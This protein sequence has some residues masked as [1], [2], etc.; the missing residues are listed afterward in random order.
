MNTKGILLG[1]M[2]IWIVS[3]PST[4]Q[5]QLSTKNKKAIE[6]YVEADNYRVRGQF[7]QAIS[8]LQQAIEKDKGF[9]EA[10]FRLGVTYKMMR[11]LDRS[12]KSYEAGLYLTI[13]QK[14][15]KGYFFELGDNYLQVGNYEK[16]RDFLSRYLDSEI[17]NKPK[18][19]QA[20]LWKRTADYAIKNKRNG[21][22]F[23]PRPLSD[24]VNC[25]PMQY[26]PVLTADEQELIFTRRLGAGNED[27]EDLVITRK[28]SAGHWTKP[29]SISPNVNSGYNEGT[30][31]ISADGRQLIFTS[32][33]GRKGFGNCDLFQSLRVGT[34]WSMPLNMGPQINSPAWESQPAL[35][36][37]GRVLYFLSDRKGGLGSR[38]IYVSYQIEPNKW[39]KAENL[40]PKINT[41]YDEISPFIHVNGRT[42]FFAANGRLGFGGYDLFR[43]EKENGEWQEPVN[44][45]YPVNN[46]EDQFSLFITADG[47]RG[48]YSHEEGSMNTSGKIYEI[49]VPED[50]QIKFRSNYVKGKVKD[51]KTGQ[52]LNARIELYD[53]AK[54]ELV[55]FVNSDSVT[56]EYLMVL[57]QGSEYGIFVSKMEYVFQSL[58]FNYESEINIEPVEVNVFLDKVTVGAIS[59][60]KNI[61]FEFDRF[62]LQDKSI[63][64]LE[65]MVR[66][67]TDNP[68][69]K[70]E[71]GGH[72]DND[73]SPAYNI[74]LSQNRA[75]SVATYLIQNGIDQKRISQKG[76]G[77]DRPMKPND[78]EE[79]K[80]DNRR[81]EFKILK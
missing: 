46:H 17:L 13:D 76:Y 41:P 63:T 57:T 66:F 9:S 56:G 77:A 26:F 78:S 3:F 20:S 39:T 55:S 72:T 40:G 47:K 51:K 34:T 54:N 44:F 79:N 50:L 80:Q 58:N 53:V 31:T 32:C 4:A 2:I 10:Y 68:N 59:V 36:A 7:N 42:L 60:L 75:Q 11:D 67:L 23:V 37:D 62:D 27:D 24:T 28:D 70:V 22:G 43:S 8:L 64:E 30:C 5:P 48:Y 6:L 49:S 81:I 38:D 14:K 65:N 71:I 33:L 74:K 19:D 52:P 29:E 21:S 16:A 35:S 73:G 1:L 61:F 15:Q 25:F 12:T 69:V 45:G 18:M